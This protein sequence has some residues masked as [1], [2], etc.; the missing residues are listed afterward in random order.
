MTYTDLKYKLS[1]IIDILNLV[2]V[3]ELLKLLICTEQQTF[4]QEGYLCS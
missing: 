1:S 4:K 3:Q 2:A